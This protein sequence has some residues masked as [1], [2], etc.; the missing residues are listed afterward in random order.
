[1]QSTKQAIFM[2][3]EEEYSF[4][5]MDVNIIE[6]YIPIEPVAKFSKNLKGIIRLRGDIIPIY[7]LRRKFGLKDIEANEDTR[8]IITTSNGLQIAYEVDQ[9][10]EILQF[11]EDQL[12]DAPSIVQNKETSYI[13][14]VSNIQGKL[15]INLNHDGILT[16][17]EQKLIDEVL[18]KI[19]E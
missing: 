4:D 13:K 1:M 5:I 14:S 18:K 17:E 12:F 11:E 15:V 8:F 16:T 6:K 2:L 3:G 7:S 10:K 9:M 19:S